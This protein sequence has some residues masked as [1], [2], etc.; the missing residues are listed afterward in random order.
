MAK[1]IIY[2]WVPVFVW[3]S[4]IFIL[5]AIPKLSTNLGVWDLILRKGAHLTEYA[6]LFLLARRALEGSFAKIA[7]SGSAAVSVLF[8]VL[9][10]VSDEFHQ[11]FVPGRSATFSDV[12]IDSCGVLIGL[13]IYLVWRQKGLRV[14]KI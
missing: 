14:N 6:V 8:S 1:K 12:C 11:S 9:Y 5:S 4:L 3:C 13:V 10:A 2:L 7:V